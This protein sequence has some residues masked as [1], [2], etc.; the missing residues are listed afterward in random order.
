MK[1][2]HSAAVCLR[3][4]ILAA[5]SCL[6]SAAALSESA[7]GPGQEGQAHEAP[8][9]EEQH[10]GGEHEYHSNMFA[11]FVGITHEARRENA[12]SLGLEYAH[13]FNKR[14]SL[15]AFSEHAFGHENFWIYAVPFAFHVGAWKAYVAP[16]V[17]DSSEHGSEFLVRIGAEYGFEVGPIEIGPQLNFDFVDGHTVTVLGVT[18]GKGF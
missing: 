15:G 4:A 5:L 17:E 14:F 7:A 9:H 8:H 12:P 6:W 10:H 1:A 11:L 18:F 16:G 13:R 2:Y 3:V